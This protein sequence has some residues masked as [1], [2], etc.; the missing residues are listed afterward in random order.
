MVMIP[1][2]YVNC[3]SL[4]FLMMFLSRSLRQ[5]GNC[6]NWLFSSEILLLAKTSKI[7]ILQNTEATV[8][9]PKYLICLV[10]ILLSL[11]AVGRVKKRQYRRNDVKRYT[12]NSRL[13]SIIFSTPATRSYCSGE[14]DNHKKERRAGNTTTKISLFALTGAIF[15]EI[16]K[17]TGATACKKVTNTVGKILH[18]K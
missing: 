12:I 1:R 9:L 4:L 6:L 7:G 14:T 13:P 8:L 5:T 10:W 17:A 18:E 16:T 2:S 11:H 15:Y 3:T